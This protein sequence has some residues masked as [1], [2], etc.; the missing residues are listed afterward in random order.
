MGERLGK[1]IGEQVDPILETVEG[2]IPISF[3]CHSLGGL[4][5]RYCLPELYFARKEKLL[6]LVNGFFSCT[7]NSAHEL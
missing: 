2:R 4:L 1:E 3:V 7:L 5:T 6:L